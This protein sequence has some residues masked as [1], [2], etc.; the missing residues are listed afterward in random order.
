MAGSLTQS[1]F[2]DAEDEA[3]E[4]IKVR[5]TT[6]G[7]AS[8]ADVAEFCRRYHYTNTPGNAQ[9]RWGLWHQHTLLGVIAY[10]LPTRRACE[11]VF[12]PEY[13]EHVWHMGRLSMAESA[14][15]NSESRLI[16]GSLR[17]IQRDHPHVWG[18]LTFAATDV[19]HIGY[20]YQATNA[21]YTGLAGSGHYFTDQSGSPRSTY[22]PGG[23]M[24][25]AE[26][27]AAWGWLRHESTGKHRYLYIL[28]TKRERRDRLAMLRHPVLPYPKALPTETGL[29]S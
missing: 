9:W 8:P 26:R 18:V 21:L 14:P 20:V 2:W 24:V 12:G 11:S 7:P 19:G 1:S 29:A 6:I 5:D 27:A 22:G 13:Y 10:N 23:W 17:A 15:P 4:P 16:G 28:G 25:T 3:T